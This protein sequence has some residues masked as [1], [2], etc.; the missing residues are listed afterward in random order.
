MLFGDKKH[1]GNFLVVQWLRH[2]ASTAGG[3][4]SVPGQE[5]EI[6]GAFQCGERKKKSFLSLF[7]DIT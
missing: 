1:V 6:L 7:K 2:R 5:T 4:G 3:K